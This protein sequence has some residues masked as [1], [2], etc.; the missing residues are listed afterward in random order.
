MNEGESRS[1]F[2]LRFTL[3]HPDAHT[4]ITGTTNPAHLREN[5]EAVLKAPLP[6]DVYAEAKRRVDEAGERPAVAS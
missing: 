5:V 6:T 1:A 2:M 3:T 4:I